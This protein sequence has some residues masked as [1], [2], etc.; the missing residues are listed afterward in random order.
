MSDKSKELEGRTWVFPE[1]ALSTDLMM[2]LKGYGLS[3]PERAKLIFSTNRPGWADAVESGDVLIG[4]R[5]FGVGSSRP[6][7]QILRVLGIQALVAESINDLFLRNCINY[8]LPAMECPGIV[9]AV[10]EGDVVRVNIYD[11]VVF[12]VRTG[13]TLLG[14]AMPSALCEIIEAGGLYEQLVKNNYI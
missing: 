11:G 14:T 5:N 3:L 8:A 1:A 7:T 10:C 2:P 13:Q 9:D 12:N 4:G 6:A